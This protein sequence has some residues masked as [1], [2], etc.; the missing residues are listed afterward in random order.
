MQNKIFFFFYLL[1]V[2]RICSRTGFQRRSVH[3]RCIDP[4]IPYLCLRVRETF[5]GTSR[6]GLLCSLPSRSTTALICQH[7]QASI[8]K[9]PHFPGVLSVPEQKPCL[10]YLFLEGLGNSLER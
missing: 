1:R 6:S 10:D 3:T 2:L 5:L 8:L 9:S 7:L 4:C